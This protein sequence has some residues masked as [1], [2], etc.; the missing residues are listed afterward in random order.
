MVSNLNSK[1]VNTTLNTIH[2][3]N[4]GNSIE[5]M[6]NTFEVTKDVVGNS[7][8]IENENIS[9]ANMNSNTIESAFKGT[10]FDLI[11]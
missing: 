6:K 10:L 11:V 1:I 9:N 4:S 5:M 7:M 2:S 3:Y 8:N